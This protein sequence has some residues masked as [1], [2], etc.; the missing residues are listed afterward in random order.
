MLA[1]AGQLS[2]ANAT[3]TDP[4]TCQR[5]EFRDVSCV[6]SS[7]STVA[8][9]A[10]EVAAAAPNGVSTNSD[11]TATRISWL[12]AARLFE[13]LWRGIIGSVASLRGLDLR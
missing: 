11:T 5:A 7:E 6:K 13:P 9:G 3:P 12:L 2:I 1:H 4:F 8:R 10:R